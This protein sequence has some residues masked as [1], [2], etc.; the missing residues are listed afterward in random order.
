MASLMQLHS[1]LMDEKE[2]RVD[3]FRKLME[4]EQAL[5]ELKMYVKMLEDKVAA[6]PVVPAPPVMHAATPRPP[7]PPRQP[8]HV[9]H[10]PPPMP[11]RPR[12]DGW[13]TW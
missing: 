4:R 13:K 8:M 1:E 9:P 5:A 7:M 12:I 10:V 2:K 3:L 6:T 11:Q